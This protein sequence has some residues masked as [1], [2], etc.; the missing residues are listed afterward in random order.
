MLLR[1][2]IEQAPQGIYIEPFDIGE[3]PLYNQDHDFAIPESVL[4]FKLQV[5]KADGILFVTPE[6]NYSMPGVLKNAIDYASRPVGDNAWNDKPVGIMGAS[7]SGFGTVR[8]QLHLRQS[9]IYLNMHPM[10]QPELHVSKVQEVFDENGV[11]V[12]E[13]LK[14]KVVDYLKAFAGWIERL[15]K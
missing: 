13:S 4:N 6:Y 7:I 1:L 15:K 3:I 5:R 14:S 2:A 8:S 10:E 9:C 11:L 12:D